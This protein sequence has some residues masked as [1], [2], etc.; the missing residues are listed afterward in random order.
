MSVTVKSKPKSR[1]S[2]TS[3][4]P[5]KTL[6]FLSKSAL[7]TPP[8][9]ASIKTFTSSNNNDR[10]TVKV[11]TVTKEVWKCDYCKQA[12]FESFEEAERHEEKCKKECQMQ[13]LL[14]CKEILQSFD[15][16]TSINKDTNDIVMDVLM[17]LDNVKDVISRESLQSTNIG[18]IVG[19][20]Q[21]MQEYLPIA[22][23]AKILVK[24]WKAIVAEE[25]KTHVE[26]TV[27]SSDKVKPKQCDTQNNSH[28]QQPPQKKQKKK[29]PAATAPIFKRTKATND[30]K[31]KPIATAKENIKP[32]ERQGNN[33]KKPLAS[34][35]TK[36]GN[37]SKLSNQK[38]V[39]DTTL[40]VEVE[41]IEESN[42]RAN[43]K[44]YPINDKDMLSEHRK[45]EYWMERR[46]A[47]EKKRIQKS[48][49]KIVS[50]KSVVS[51]DS[52][53]KNRA[54]VASIFHRK[55]GISQQNSAC[56]ATSATT[57]G[58]S[59]GIGS[60]LSAKSPLDLTATTPAD[61]NVDESSKIV[62]KEKKR[63]KKIGKGLE[64]KNI[65]PRFPVPNH[66]VGNDEEIEEKELHFLPSQAK[67]NIVKTP[68]YQCGIDN[69][70]SCSTL[71][72]PMSS[73]CSHDE[74]RHPE[75][76]RLHSY[77][78]SIFRPSPKQ[79]DVEMMIIDDVS[80]P[81]QWSDK[82]TMNCVP[83]DVYGEKNKNVAEEL[84][85]FVN[86]WKSHRQQAIVAAEIA[87]QKRK[88]T[89]KNKKTSRKRRYDSDDDFL[90]D[91]E[92]EGGLPKLFVLHGPVGSGKTSL[93]YAVAKKS[94]CVILEINTTDDRG[95]TSL[96]KALE[97][98][99]QSH[100]SLA[101]LKRKNNFFAEDADLQDTDDEDESKSSLAIILI[102]EGK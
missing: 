47:E 84:L 2:I 25:D 8:P 78:S 43:D 79:Q 88:G 69:V 5:Q 82:Y 49:E 51:C 54:E 3:P 31:P 89:K 12:K 9:M 40:D 60:G 75:A 52:R 15:S 23:K 29:A 19:K 81:K 38:E 6:T 97:E 66:V 11:G 95:G 100:S 20:L 57:P 21:K 4:K 58:K 72:D 102:D 64:S 10:S 35:F 87:H 27:E 70:S 83:H 76:D 7:I 101:L 55:I 73:L 32:R 41:V 1:K 18:R 90:S 59:T 68:K 37:V 28:L 85:S 36:Q 63:I 34:I 71:W 67:E 14:S 44:D 13:A 65:A 98:C 16:V 74:N 86:D 45:A 91:S 50:N 17:K 48:K 77:F 96:K 53:G 24:E 26:S 61:K 92:D 62:T 46:R 99:T 42:Q 94:N 33:T 93:A 22:K 39:D 80:G 56:A 30:A